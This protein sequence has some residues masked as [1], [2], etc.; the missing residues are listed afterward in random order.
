MLLKLDGIEEP[1]RMTFDEA[2]AQVI[3][4][5]QD[6]LDA[7]FTERLRREANVRTYPERLS[8]AFADQRTD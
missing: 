5:Y 7:R 1:R 3:T 2:R 8:G 6:V 4:E